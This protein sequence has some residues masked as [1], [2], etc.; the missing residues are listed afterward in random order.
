MRAPF[1]LALAL[2]CTTGSAQHA[3]PLAARSL[4]LFREASAAPALEHAVAH[5]TTAT[6]DEAVLQRILLVKPAAFTLAVPHNGSVWTVE[7]ERKEVSVPGMQVLTDQGVYTGQVGGMHYRGRL[8]GDGGSLAAFSFFHGKVIG[9]ISSLALGDVVVGPLQGDAARH[10]IYSAHDLRTTFAKA[11]SMPPTEAAE[12]PA[13]A[14]GTAANDRSEQCLRIYYELSDQLYAGNGSDLGATM[15]WLTAVHNIVAT[16]FAN[17]GI[18]IAISEVFIWTTPMPFPMNDPLNDV[19]AFAAYRNT[20]NGDIAYCL[21]I[22]GASGA[23][24]LANLC[25]HPYAGSDIQLAYEQLPLFSFTVNNMAHELGHAAGSPHTH[26]CAWNGN[27]TQ[28]D[29]CGNEGLPFPP[30]GCYDPENPIIPP[31]G[32]GTIMSYC[33]AALAAGFGPQPRQRMLDHMAASPCLG[34]DCITSCVNTVDSLRAEDITP[35]S[36]HIAF[37]SSDPAVTS[38]EI[39]ILGP[40]LEPLTDWLTITEPAYDATGLTPGWFHR[41]EVRTTC[42]A[43]FS[44]YMVRYV[45]FLAPTTECGIQ[46]TD[47][48]EGMPYLYDCIAA[49][50]TFVP[51]GP[52]IAVTLEFSVFAVEPDSDFFMVYNGPDVNSPIIGEFTGTTVPPSITSTAPGG[53]LTVAFRCDRLEWQK[54]QGWVYTV[55]CGEQIITGA[56]DATVQ[57]VPLRYYPVPAQDLLH[58]EYLLPVAGPVDMR[59][60]DM[61]GRSVAAPIAARRAA[62]R[63]TESIGL[64]SLASGN[65]VLRL[66]TPGCSTTVR[67]MKQ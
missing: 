25:N 62:G 48:G 38:W 5:A 51:Y 30:I 24:N 18:T 19:G 43:P 46:I 31:L 33:A 21:N 7:L 27:N 3:D 17:E 41:A 34:T 64:S 44:G 63:H 1:L 40:F 28:I 60:L 36:A 20:F 42:P 54:Y 22:S 61:Q 15:D 6:L 26:D 45:E 29:D 50:R 8:S 32:E 55:S 16:V 47:L 2:L 37:R 56:A 49:P 52:G 67:F 10:V 65:Y 13:H 4:R 12:T 14:A 66:T 53:E 23:A 57:G 9:V 59:L 11:C 35:F 39:R 58:V